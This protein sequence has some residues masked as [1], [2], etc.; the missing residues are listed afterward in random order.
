M[1]NDFNG[2]AS[3][4]NL[5]VNAIS[6][7]NQ[8]FLSFFSSSVSPL[9]F[10]SLTLIYKLS[11]SLEENVFFFLAN[12]AERGDMKQI[13]LP[14]IIWYRIEQ[15]TTLLR[16]KTRPIC[17]VDSTALVTDANEIEQQ[18]QQER[19]KFQTFLRFHF[20]VFSLT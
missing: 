20:S 8:A 4:Y 6:T 2:S 17:Y 12:K 7:I 1:K 14:Q 13:K 10:I 16:R 9:F 11:A 3:T 19:K 5:A 18:Q 15:Q